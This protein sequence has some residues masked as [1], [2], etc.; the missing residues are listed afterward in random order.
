MKRKRKLKNLSHQFLKCIRKRTRK[1]SQA[2]NLAQNRCQVFLTK[3]QNY[4]LL[5]KKMT[6]AKV[7]R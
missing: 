7:M 5:K 4:K 1:T 3:R 2:M 6:E